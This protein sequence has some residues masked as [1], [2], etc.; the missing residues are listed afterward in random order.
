METRDLEFESTADLFNEIGLR[1]ECA[2]LV[3][4]PNVKAPEI[5]FEAII[6]KNTRVN[7]KIEDL[8]VILEDIAY[9]LLEGDLKE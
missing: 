3:R 1:S 6:S 9:Q 2:I 8:G 5:D 4:I 7:D